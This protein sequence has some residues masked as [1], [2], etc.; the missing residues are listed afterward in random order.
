MKILIA[1]FTKIKYMPYLKFY[2]N[3]ID[4]ENN[5]IHILFWNRDCKEETLDIEKYKYH[6]FRFYQEDD[7]KKIF[8]IKS[9]IKYRNFAKKILMKESFDKIIILHSLPAVLLN[10]ILRIRFKNKYIFDFRDVTYEKFYFFRKII[11][12]LCNNSYATFCSSRGYLK[13]LPK[14]NKILI[15]HM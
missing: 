6:E 7:V 11:H 9:F 4:C 2:L 8:K 15:S 13:Y 3:N 12:I 1:G 10:D 14:S 5:E